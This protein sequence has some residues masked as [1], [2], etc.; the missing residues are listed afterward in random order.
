MGKIGKDW[1]LEI[2][3]SHQGFT[4]AS[5]DGNA[6]NERH[7]SALFKKWCNVMRKL[8]QQNVIV[9]SGLVATILLVLLGLLSILETC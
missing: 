3:K 6:Y 1:E 9:I 2:A 8:F 7:A 5:F 4:L